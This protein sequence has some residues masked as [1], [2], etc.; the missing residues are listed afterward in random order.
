MLKYERLVLGDLMTNCYLVW[1]EESKEAV[2]IDPADSGVEISEEIQ[3]RQ[4][5]PITIVATHGHFDHILGALD[6]KLIYNLPLAMHFGDLF[7]VKRMRESAEFF[8]KRRIRTP[9][10]EAVEID[11]TRAKAIRLGE[12]RLKILKTPGH[13]PGGL[14]F[15]SPEGGWIITGDTVFAG[16][17]YG[18]TTHEYS[19][20]AVLNNSLLKIFE[21][22]NNVLILPGHGDET[23]VG[24]AKHKLP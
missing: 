21:L 2:V 1:D 19:S 22:P 10:I 20:K 13:T 15:Y 6:L 11:L 24:E 12:Y 16:E 4:L 7:L 5:K 18:E 9:N 23:T 14:C 17:M 3:R 8:L